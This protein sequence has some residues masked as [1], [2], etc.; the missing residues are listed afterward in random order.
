MKLI[1]FLLIFPIFL[2]GADQKDDQ[3][4]AL[5]R[6]KKFV[7]AGALYES[8]LQESPNDPDLL[9]SLGRVKV[10]LN[11]KNA[12]I[13]L[14][15]KA[16]KIDPKRDDIRTALGY[17]Y[18][19][20]GQL[21]ESEA[22]FKRVLK[23]APDSS[24]ALAGLGILAMRS[25]KDQ[26]A[27]ELFQKALKI[28][29]NEPT[30]LFYL[31]GIRTR[32]K[33][34]AEAE[35]LYAALLA[36]DPSNE[37]ALAGMGSV[38]VQQNQESK[39]EHYYQ[40][41]LE[42]N[43][44]NEAALA[45]FGRNY[46]KE[47]NYIKAREYFSKLVE[48]APSNPDYQGALKTI[49]EASLEEQARD[50]QQFKDKEGAAQIYRQ[51]IEQSSNKTRYY[52][53]LGALYIDQGNRDKTIDLYKEAIA[54]YPAD[55]ELKNALAMQY[56]DR[57]IKELEI[58]P[59]AIFHNPLQNARIND[60][61][62]KAKSLFEDV[63]AQDPTDPAALAGF[64]RLIQLFGKADSQDIVYFE[65]LMKKNPDNVDLLLSFGRIKMA[66]DHKKEAI[67]LYLKALEID[68]KRVDIRTTLG[69]AYLFDNQLEESQLIFKQVLQ[70][71]S[72][73]SDALAGMGVLAF[74]EHNDNEAAVL[75][76]HALKND[77]NQP[78]AL[79]YLANLRLKQ[80]KYLE[81]E[82]LYTRLL[83]LEPHNDDALAGMARIAAQQHQLDK[84][85]QYDFEALEINPNNEAAL[86][87]FTSLFLKQKNYAKAMQ[88]YSKLL[89]I[90]PANSDYQEGL[91]T[92][93]EAPLE[94]KAQ[95]FQQAND[96]AHAISLYRQLI[97][98]SPK[99]SKYYLRLGVIYVSQKRQDEAI[100]MYAHALTLKLDDDKDLSNALAFLYLNKALSQ[101]ENGPFDES[102]FPLLY[103]RSQYYE[104]RARSLFE[105]VLN[106]DK[107]NALALAGMGR[108]AL[109]DGEP[110]LAENLYFESLAKDDK[111]TTALSYLASLQTLEK[112]YYTAYDTYHYLLALNPTDADSKKNYQ[113]LLKS[114][115][116]ALD[117]TF[118][119]EE[120]NE[121]DPITATTKEWTA[122]LKNYGATIGLGSA[123]RDHLK[124]YANLQRNYI[125]LN[126]LIT[127]L[128]IYGVQIVQPDIGFTWSDSPY[129]SF[130]GGCQVAFYRQYWRST[131]KT[132]TGHY[133]LPYFR[134]SYAKDYHSFTLETVG[135]ALLVAR[136]FAS[137]QSTL[138]AR[139]FLNAVYE[140]DLGKKRAIGFAGSYAVYKNRI[141]DNRYEYGSAWLRLTP[142]CYW[143]NLSLKYQ[144]VY[145]RFDVL[146]VD[147][148]TYRPQVSHYLK[149][150][151]SKKWLDDHLLTEAGYSHC[152]Q[153]SFESGQIITVVPVAQ[154]HW[155][156]RRINAAYARLSYL[157]EDYLTF[158]VTGT[159]S[160][161]NFDYTTASV[162][163]NLHVRF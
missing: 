39:A 94:E 75:F 7:E 81:A 86:E 100:E 82:K 131:F 103:L 128:H 124:I 52:L 33:N 105:H 66:L 10:A 80:K 72:E 34:Y 41:A 91:Q 24:A 55:K 137:F 140:Y 89:Q 136:N 162:L 62:T 155:V 139:Q 9:L 93:K 122:R 15:L 163:A 54:L 40:K 29:V 157:F 129:F 26:E 61:Y 74:R 59:F 69:Y 19:F 1:F 70:E 151:F 97:V 77:A 51:L 56:L 112:K 64:S 8:L 88:F 106:Q 16:L 4:K 115:N 67:Q 13:E 83:K 65:T 92:A 102:R 68:P 31:A 149:I 73:N 101:V 118:G 27:E 28:E 98:M 150:D 71:N 38:A 126:N 5:V 134:L 119:Y 148:Y 147:Y 22:S 116:P 85:E 49:H 158:T 76:Q 3:A 135:D 79:F 46:L 2:C 45:F 42:A 104:I 44:G 130:G 99:K 159:Y 32:Q 111:N 154:F 17:A 36:Q 96:F 37:D 53:R 11:Q 146:T 58:T 110:D 48:I 123:V 12:G 107:E 57:A 132:N 87:F 108:L 161:D 84:A 141:K 144:F 142:P 145:G 120:E 25:H 18:L 152:W 21:E 113:E 63:L 156:N 90:D 43:P 127:H 121:K 153:R 30:A 78:T 60:N 95:A 143:K 23:E 14:Y 138:I 125:V 117:I 50:L 20:D 114:K 6:D 160:K 133:I 35:M 109:L 47:K